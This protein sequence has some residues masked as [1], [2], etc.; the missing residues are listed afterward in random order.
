MRWSRTFL[1]GLIRPLS[2]GVYCYLPLGH[3]ALRKARNIV[4]EEMDLTGAAE[5]SLPA[6]QPPELWKE[7]GRYETF[8]EILMRV[9]DRRG[10]E[11]VLGPTHEEVV[12]H[13]VRNE[14]TSHRQLPVILYQIQTKFRDEPRV[15]FGVVR[16]REFVMK[17][18]YS[19]DRTADGM[20]RSY[21]A[22][23]DAY[24]RI[25]TRAGLDFLAVEADAG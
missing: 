10:A 17:D 12:T 24:L 8:G 2:A 19:F 4:R 14:I 9:R 23:Y 7:S 15:R 11:H 3:R 5:L 20:N 18:A 16:T 1:P 21:Q 25:F 13:L 6:L 22:M